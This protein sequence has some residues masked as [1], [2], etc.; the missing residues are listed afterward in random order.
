MWLCFFYA[1][2]GIQVNGVDY[3][4]PMDASISNQDMVCFEAMSVNDMV[5]KFEEFPENTN[6]IILDACCDNPFRSW[7]RGSGRGFRAV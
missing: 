3:S 4:I 7:V 1:D 6:I 5:A 2:H